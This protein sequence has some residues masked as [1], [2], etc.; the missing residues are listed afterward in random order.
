MSEPTPIRDNGPYESADQ[1]REQWGAVTF[2]IPRAEGPA[3]EAALSGVVLSEALMIAGVQPSEYERDALAE[4][5][6]SV[7]PAVAQVVAGWVIRA[8]L[9]GAEGDPAA[10]TAR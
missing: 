10:R 9:V 5:A 2:G 7:C 6:G 8:R 1:A 3:G 4:L